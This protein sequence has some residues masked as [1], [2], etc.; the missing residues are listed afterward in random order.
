[1][2][3]GNF[4]QIVSRENNVFEGLTLLNVTGSWPD[5]L[6]NKEHIHTAHYKK[7]TTYD[8]KIL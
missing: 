2:G 3:G 8:Q 7:V 1:M 5:Q 4:L 6:G